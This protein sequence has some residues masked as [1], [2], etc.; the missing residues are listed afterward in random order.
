M[1]SDMLIQWYKEHNIEHRTTNGF[2]TYLD[3]WRKEDT[4]FD[5]DYG[6]MDSRLIELE[7]HKIQF[8]H[9]FDYD[10]FIYVFLKIYYNDDYIG[11]YKS[12]YTLDGDDE[13]DILKFEENR[14]IKILVETTNNSI[15]I[16][17]KALK[18]GI[19]NE[20]VSKITG[21]RSSLIAD[22]KSKIS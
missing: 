9:I 11:T 6:E 3:N 19:P 13:D 18:E 16:A 14:F 8:T 1:N 5:F 2:W 4:D 20:V 17:E 12:V 21:L 22:I 15:K 10:D 7:V